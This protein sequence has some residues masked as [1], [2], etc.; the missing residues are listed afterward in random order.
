MLTMINI[1]IPTNPEKSKNQNAAE[2]LPPA[3]SMMA[4]AMNGPTKADVF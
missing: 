4:E 1:A 3:S 2:V